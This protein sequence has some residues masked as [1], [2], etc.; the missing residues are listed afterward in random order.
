MRYA[1]GS[2]AL[3]GT[4][5]R[6]AG[7][8]GVAAQMSG[9]SGLAERYAAALFE[10]VEER[11]ELDQTASD[12]ADL[13]RMI[14]ESADLRRLISSPAIGRAEQ[15]RALATVLERGGASDLVRRFVGLVA[16]NRRLFA[17]LA[18]IESF[19]A[20]LAR[21]RGETVASVVS[22]R[23]LSDTQKNAVAEALRRAVG[24][25]VTVALSV[26]ESL[27]GGLVVRVGSRQIDSSLRTKLERLQFAMKGTR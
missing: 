18:M 6:K 23:P 14:A 11:R 25:K 4:V 1:K 20:E 19:L 12:L 3:G 27:I 10:L 8:G 15:G 24:A 26:D 16:S 21:R 2:R 17:L 7:A 5:H 9:L 13:R 22:A